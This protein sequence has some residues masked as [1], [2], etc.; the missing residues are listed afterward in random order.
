MIVE[1]IDHNRVRKVLVGSYLCKLT[2][3]HPAGYH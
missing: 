3:L 2:S 1:I